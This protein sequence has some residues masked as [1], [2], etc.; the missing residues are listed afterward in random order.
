MDRPDRRGVGGD[1][2]ME[3]GVVMAIQFT[4]YLRP[5]GRKS[6][7]TIERSAEIEVKAQKIID[8]GYNFECEVLRTGEIHLD[9][10][11][12]ER[13]IAVEVVPNGPEVVAAVDRIVERAFQSLG[14]S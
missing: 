1:L 5:N 9:C 10:C 8:A 6:Q 14:L 3:K 13:E 4:Q 11:N 12:M 7:V 2:T